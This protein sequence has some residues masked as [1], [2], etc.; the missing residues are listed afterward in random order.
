MFG[1]TKGQ[2]EEEREKIY[3]KIEQQVAY[4]RDKANAKKKVHFLLA[5]VQNFQVLNGYQTAR[6]ISAIPKYITLY[7]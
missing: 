2:T 4:E 5:A 3:K 6:L 7:D 1:K